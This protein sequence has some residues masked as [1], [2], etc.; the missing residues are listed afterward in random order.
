MAVLLLMVLLAAGGCA[1]KSVAPPPG[2]SPQS[3][4]HSAA[5]GKAASVLR[6]ARSVIGAPYRW[7]GES[8]R[9][10]FDCSGLVWYVYRQNG[11]SLPRVSWQQFGAG[12]SIKYGQLRPGDLIF[13]KVEKGAKSLHVGIVTDRGTFIHAPS[14]GKRVMESSLNNT[15][16]R[17]HYVGARRV[18]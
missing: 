13:H 7:G 4:K 3:V 9:S 11:I 2:A 16:W 8:P 10:G 17:E 18:L 5:K 6:M 1:T 14:S 15:Y 12:S